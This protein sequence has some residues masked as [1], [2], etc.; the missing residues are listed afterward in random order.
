MGISLPQIN[1]GVFARTF[2]VRRGTRELDKILV[3]VGS[4]RIEQIVAAGDP[5]SKHI[6]PDKM[7]AIRELVAA[8]PWVAN[9]ITDEDFLRMLPPWFLQIVA[10]HGDPGKQWLVREIRWIRSLFSG[11]A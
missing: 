8:Y 4:Q 11:Q 7:E 5:I 3:Q 6:P 1:G 9:L 10:A 2:A